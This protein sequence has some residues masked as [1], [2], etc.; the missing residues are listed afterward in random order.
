MAGRSIEPHSRDRAA[1]LARLRVA[2]DMLQGMTLLHE[3]QTDMAATDLERTGD[4]RM[5]RCRS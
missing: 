4:L 2:H 5:Q 1:T 3:E